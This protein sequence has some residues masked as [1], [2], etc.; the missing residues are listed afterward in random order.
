MI[1]LDKNIKITIICYTLFSIFLYNLRLPIMFHNNGEFKCF[2]LGKNKTI[3]P[4]WLVTLLFG[5]FVHFVVLI[6]NTDYL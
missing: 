4:F 3:Y 6:K 1:S 2:G 5:L